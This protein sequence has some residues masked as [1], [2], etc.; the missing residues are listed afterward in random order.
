M[1]VFLSIV[2]EEKHPRGG[3]VLDQVVEE[4]LG[5]GVNPVQVLEDNAQRL[6]LTLPQQEVPDRGHRLLSPLARVQRL[7]LRIL[8]RHVEERKESRHSDGQLLVER[9][10]LADDLLP[11]LLLLG[12]IVN[13]E[14]RSQEIDDRPVGCRLAIG[15]GAR[16]HDT[17][18]RH[19]F[20][21][22]ELVKEP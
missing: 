19:S 5:L 14:V 9:Q 13:V 16:F 7:P 6:D 1:P 2:D 3:K 11:D 10:H 22:S 17:P 18:A 4:G 20:R 15:E 8:D 21:T 12:P